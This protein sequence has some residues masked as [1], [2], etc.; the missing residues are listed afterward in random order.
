[1]NSFIEHFAF[2]QAR[3]HNFKELYY[4]LKQKNS[5]IVCS[6]IQSVYLASY[7]QIHKKTITKIEQEYKKEQRE[8]IN[9][10]KKVEKA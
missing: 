4:D 6:G 2:D 10:I 1:M 8:N 5:P 9:S 7:F 3:S